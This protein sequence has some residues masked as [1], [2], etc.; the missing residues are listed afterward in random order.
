MLFGRAL[1]TFVLTHPMDLL[2]TIPLTTSPV[3]A[4]PRATYL[5]GVARA[6][7][8]L[9]MDLSGFEPDHAVVLIGHGALVGI[10]ID[11]PLSY[12][13]GEDAESRLSDVA[14][15]SPRAAHHESILRHAMSLAPVMPV[16]FGTVFSSRDRLVALLESNHDVIAAFL[17]R[18]T[19]AQEWHVRLLL[20]RAAALDAHASDLLRA[21][22]GASPGARYLLEK[23]IRQQASGSLAAALDD[24]AAAIVG[25]LRTLCL[26]TRERR[27]SRAGSPREDGLEPLA[28]TAC[29]VANDALAGLRQRTLELSEEFAP[30]GIR[31]QFTGPWPAYSFC[32]TLTEP[33]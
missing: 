19:H 8:D 25:H 31:V 6:T 2:H 23:K 20:D 14:W 11:L 28:S 33:T 15:L 18:V 26:E 13:A 4:E 22:A 27:S 21:A 30:A 12:F 1:L 9:P 17:S 16:R 3:L 10:A 24:S 5:V 7:P 29:L 32:P